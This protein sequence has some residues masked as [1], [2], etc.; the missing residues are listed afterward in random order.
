MQVMG[1][2][3]PGVIMGVGVEICAI[4]GDSEKWECYFYMY[5]KEVKKVGTMVIKSIKNQ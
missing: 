1:N 5:S 4:N 2:F 3:R